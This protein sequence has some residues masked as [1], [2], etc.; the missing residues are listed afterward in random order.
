MMM[1]PDCG[2]AFLGPHAAQELFGHLL[3][4]PRS[5]KAKEPNTS[6]GVT[7]LVPCPR[8]LAVCGVCG[9]PATVCLQGP[10]SNPEARREYGGLTFYRCCRHEDV[11]KEYTKYPPEK[12][13]IIHRGKVATCGVDLEFEVDVSRGSH[14]DYSDVNPPDEVPPCCP[15]GHE[16]TPAEVAFLEVKVRVVFEQW[17]LSGGLDLALVER[18]VAKADSLEDR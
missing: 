15:K 6:R 12:P 10:P 14:G 8:S 16:F 4:C 5:P 1:C 3:K 7:L 2:D 17:V 9:E 13:P 18:D 11:A